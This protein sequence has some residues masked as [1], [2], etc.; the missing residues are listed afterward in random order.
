MATKNSKSAVSSVP[1]GLLRLGL[2]SRLFLVLGVLVVLIVAGSIRAIRS[3]GAETADA[4]LEESLERSHSVHSGFQQRR[5]EQLSLVAEAFTSNSAITT[6]IAEAA[7]GRDRASILDQLYERQ[8]ELGF[9]FAIVL[10]TG[11]RVLARTDSPDTSGENLS[12][13]PLVSKVMDD[14][15][16]F[17]IWRR[18][19]ELFNGVAVPLVQDFDLFGYLVCGYAIDND[20]AREVR[21]AEFQ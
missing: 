3:V 16:A 20:F 10:D 18:N 4:S 1:R 15:D 2:F 12:E 5:F 8:E 17:G 21:N 13:R 19:Q 7:E 9:D 14:N 11:G 6:F